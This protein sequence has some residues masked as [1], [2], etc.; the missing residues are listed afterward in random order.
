MSFDITNLILHKRNF[1]SEE[2]CGFLIDYYE[3]HKARSGTEHCPEATTGIDTYSSFSVI[4]VKYGD[5]EHEFISKKIEKMI[6]LYHDHTDQFDMF[7]MLRKYSLLYSHKLRLMK[8][9]EG[10]KIHPHSDHDPY[11]YG[12]CTFN[13]NDDY[14]GGEFSFFKDKKIIKLEK[15][16]ALIFP[17]DY[18]WVHEVKPIKKGVRYSTN[19]FLQCL[20]SSI[21]ENLR[22]FRDVLEKNYKFN[23]DDG[24]KY[25]IE[26]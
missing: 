6:N 21:I 19:C 18:F 26:K 9:E 8:Y 2:E 15:G 5:K 3:K 11:V 20:P 13:L 12:S 1:L 22:R 17:A 7:H 4:D 23:S 16:D 25:N 24:L 14:Q 10:C